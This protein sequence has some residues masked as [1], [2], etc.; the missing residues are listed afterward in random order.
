M[1][2][3]VPSYACIPCVLQ[4]ESRKVPGIG[5]SITSSDDQ[6]RDTY[7]KYY[8]CIKNRCPT[9][10]TVALHY[11]INNHW[12]TRGWWEIPAAVRVGG[13]FLGQMGHGGVSAET[14]CLAASNNRV[15]YTYGRALS[16]VRDHRSGKMMTYEWREDP[17]CR[18]CYWTP[19]GGKSYP[20]KKHTASAHSGGKHTSV[21]DCN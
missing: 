10:V 17:G 1:L 3:V 2:H 14:H 8:I 13:A 12:V 20:F 18:N 19:P 11:K 15:F 6:V 16:A 5:A 7:E 21:I 9:P 4:T